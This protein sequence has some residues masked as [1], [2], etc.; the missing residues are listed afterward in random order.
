M[1]TYSVDLKSLKTVGHITTEITDDMLHVTTTKRLS[2]RF[3]KA[4]MPLQSFI[5]LP[6]TYRLPLRLDIQLKIDAPGFYVFLGNGHVNFATPWSDNRNIDDI[7]EPRYKPRQFYNHIP[8]NRL[9]SLSIIY[10]LKD[11]Q[12][13]ID[14]EER[15][16]SKK[17]PYMT[18]RSF[19]QC[20]ESGFPIK[21]TCDKRT[22]LVIK[23]L[24][25]IE[26]DN[27]PPLTTL[28]KE[29]PQPTTRNEAVEQG[30]KPTFEA[31]IAQLPDDIQSDIR[32]SDRFLKQ[33]KP[34]SFRRQI[35]KNGTKITYLASKHGFSYAIYPSNDIMH[36]SLN[37]YVITNKKPDAWHRKDDKMEA[38]LNE[39][40]KAHPDIAK[41]LYHHLR[42]CIHC[43]NQCAVKTLYEF[44]DEGLLTCHGIMEFKMFTSDF[45]K[46]RLFIDTINRLLDKA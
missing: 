28:G 23:S 35:D 41:N 33:M 18:S 10:G 39:L 7:I 1:T 26:Y 4:N 9:T 38:T 13:L 11:I 6:N 5:E 17:E 32:K 40:A 45:E 20:N 36:H 29:L 15:F 25:V 42:E 37:W 12:I 2:V 14:D 46:V 44:E 43:N 30:V 31:C 8:L 22:H 27:L 3:D 21:L 24:S 34:L 19:N 16:Y